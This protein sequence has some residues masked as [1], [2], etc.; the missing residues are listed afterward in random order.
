M[1]YAFLLFAALAMADTPP[2]AD[3]NLSMN[4]LHAIFPGMQISLVPGKRIN[5]SRSIKR[6]PYEL[7]SPDALANATVYR[8]IGKPTNQAEKDASGQLTGAKF[9]N[10]RL[11]RFQMFRWPQTT[12]LLAVLQYDFEDSSPTDGVPVDRASGTT[13]ERRRNVEGGGTVSS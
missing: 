10:T 1:R 12:A 7:D 8:V 3:E 5:N 9:S 2:I 11:V 13:S 6:S 4:A